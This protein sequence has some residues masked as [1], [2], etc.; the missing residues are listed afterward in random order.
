MGERGKKF[1][2]LV[3]SC[4][5]SPLSFAASLHRASFFRYNQIAGGWA[6]AG[7]RFGVFER[8][9]RASLSNDAC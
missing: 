1:Q 5:P 8:K 6:A 9:V 7:V 3:V 4:L 2:S